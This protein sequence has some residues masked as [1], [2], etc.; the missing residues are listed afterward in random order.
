MI[1]IAMANNIFM[2][3]TKKRKYPAHGPKKLLC[4]LVP[5]EFLGKLLKKCKQTNRAQP[6]PAVADENKV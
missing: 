4:D 2:C 5:L 3:F 1:A 6:D